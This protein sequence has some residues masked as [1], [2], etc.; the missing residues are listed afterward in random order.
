MSEQSKTG[1][2]VI[3]RRGEYR[4]QEGEVLNVDQTREEYAVKFASG[5]VAVV[6]FSNVRTPAVRTF[7]EKEVADVLQ[8]VIDRGHPDAV[9]MALNALGEDSRGVAALLSWPIEGPPA[10]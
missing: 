4:N 8:N 3:I 6:K 10:S 5:T 9:S 1:D 7:T 2:R